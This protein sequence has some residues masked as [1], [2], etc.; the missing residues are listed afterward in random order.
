MEPTEDATEPQGVGLQGALVKM[1]MSSDVAVLLDEIP[2]GPMREAAVANVMAKPASFWTERAARQVR[3]TYYRLVF[4]GLYYSS[5]WGNASK[6]YGPLPLPDKSVWNVQLTGTPHRVSAING[7]NHDSIVVSYK[8]DTMI[9]TDKDS[10]GKV[11]PSLATLGGTADEVFTLPTDPDLLLQR[12]G[13]A[14]MDEEEYPPGSVFEENT[15]YFYDDTCKAGNSWCHITEQPGESCIN[16]VNK[17]VGDVKTTMHFTR[18]PYDA[19]LASKYRVGAITNRDGADLA[20]M[21]KGM[22]E[23]KK[24]AYRFFAPGSCELEEGVIAKLG[25]RRLLMFSAIVQ[26]NGTQPVH[27]GDVTDSNNPWVRSGAF[28]FSA[29]HGHYHFSHYGTFNY[30]GAPGSKRAFCLEDTNRFHNDETTPLTADHQSC[31]YQGIGAGW[32]DEYQFGLPGQW[33]D[34][35][36][37]DTRKAHPLTFDSNPDMFLCEGKPALDSNGQLILDPSPFKDAQ[38]NTVS[39]VRC[40]MPTTWHDNNVGTVSVSSPGGSFVTESCKLGEIGHDRDCGYAAQTQLR[41]C[42]AGSTVTLTCKNTGAPQALR[43]CEKSG[44]LGVGVAC[45]FR[46]SVAN[47][48]I[49]GSTTFSFT[50]PAVR[51]YPGAGG[52][53]LY[54]A[55]V[56]PSMGT[57]SVTCN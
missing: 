8:F 20:V 7:Q 21:Q 56:V 44:A 45:T 35:T 32:G 14:C 16:A 27:I 54:N 24:I 22:E 18:V 48:T 11:D 6:V 51:D 9:V 43:I 25:W 10:P 50:C 36:D 49:N 29:C 28:E 5:D 52:Y 23:E 1:E 19:T 55:S 34:I 30:N 17:R 26:N 33:V 57:G 2:A 31:H 41:S 47:P 42:Q 38:G 40:N 3:L 13:Y 46:D 39:R 15:W 53:S 12:T 4:R 37:V